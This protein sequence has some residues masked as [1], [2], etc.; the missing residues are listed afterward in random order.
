L[1][2]SVG[3]EVLN[4]VN[5]YVPTIV[6]PPPF[7]PPPVFPPPPFPFPPELFAEAPTND[8]SIGSFSQKLIVGFLLLSFLLF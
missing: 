1:F 8:G 5:L 3:I 4:A 2:K 7:P 6:E